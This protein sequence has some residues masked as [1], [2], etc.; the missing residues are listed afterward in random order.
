LCDDAQCL[1]STAQSASRNAQSL[2]D[3]WQSV[4]R[5]AQS[6]RGTFVTG[7]F[8]RRTRAIGAGQI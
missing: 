8:C 5:D 7:K 1:S 4:Q 6:V 2:R 3:K